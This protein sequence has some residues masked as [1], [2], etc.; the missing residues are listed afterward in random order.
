MAAPSSLVGQTVSHYRILEKLGGG[1]MGVV[2]KAEDTRLNRFVALKFLPDDVAND[3]HALARFKREAQAASA[4]SHHNIC[5]IHDIGEENGRA[6][7]AMEYLQ[8]QTL[9]HFIQQHPLPT[10][11][12]LDLAIQIADALDAAHVRGIIHRDMKPANIFVTD[13][14]QAKILDFGLAKVSSRNVI[15]QPDITAATVDASDDSLTSPGSAVGTVAYMSPEQVRGD[16]LDVRSDLFSFGVVLYEMATGHLAFPGKTSGVIIDAILNRAP[17][18]PIRLK[19]DLPAPL[20]EIIN[21]ALEK[22]RDVRYQHASEIRADLQRLKR[23]S[24]SGQLPRAL[25]TATAPKAPVRLGQGLSHPAAYLLGALVLVAIAATGIYEWSSKGLSR[26]LVEPSDVMNI[27]RL[28]D[29]GKSF[30]AAISPDGKYVAHVVEGVGGQSLCVRQIPTNSDL[31]II[32]PSKLSYEDL[33][34]S[35]DGNYIYF[36]SRQEGTPFDFKHLPGSGVLYRVPAIGGTQQKLLEGV[37]PP[38]VFSPDGERLIFWRDVTLMWANNDGTRVRALVNSGRFVPGISVLMHARSDAGLAVSPDGT[39]IAWFAKP[40]VVTFT[41]ADALGAELGAQPY[42]SLRP[43]EVSP[44]TWFNVERLAWISDGSGILMDAAEQASF[45][46][47]QLWF[48]PYPGG[49]TRRITNDLDDYHGVSLSADSSTLVTSQRRVLSEILISERGSASAGRQVSSATGRYEGRE[50]IAWAP[51][52]KLIFTV[53]AGER[54]DIWIMEADGSNRK[55]LTAESGANTWPTVSPDGRSIF[56]TSDRRGQPNI[57]KMAMDGSNL[58]QITHGDQDG[59]PSISAEG[60]WVVYAG[61][62][63]AKGKPAAVWKVAA[64]GGEPTEIAEL[65]GF[66]SVATISPDG[67]M[68]ACTLFDFFKGVLKVELL[69]VEAGK[70][71]NQEYILPIQI[72]NPFSTHMPLVRWSPDGR[73][74]TYT[75]TRDNISNIWSQPLSGGPP[76]QVTNFTSGRIFSYVWSR[77]GEEVVVARGSER[78]DLVLIANFRSR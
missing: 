23:D 22:N 30:L 26:S 25:T 35:R 7:I 28:T 63:S 46:P 40:H 68:I 59:E 78:S 47:S 8:G 36:V 1:G 70:Q 49:K 33:V 69:P 4:L 48:I 65:T 66:G 21:K 34:F 11:Q 77:D 24:E 17:V 3:P 75:D 52:G 56:F 5:T 58:T 67:K 54:S 71:L 43:R 31:Q 41:I 18:S 6:F 57:W 55:Q 20:E 44:E 64:G 50:G 13:R 62:A 42:S 16:K 38:V 19:P 29:N 12:V 73:S 76:K 15:E 61:S 74:L 72:E 32:S 45:N 53:R 9:K 39:T 51:D 60:K 14:G 27:T 2:Y 37:Q 10:G